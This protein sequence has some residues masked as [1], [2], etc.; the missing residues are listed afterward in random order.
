M[1]LLTL[2]LLVKLTSSFTYYYNAGHA[3]TMQELE[4]T[5]INHWSNWDLLIKLL[6]RR[7]TELQLTLSV[8]MHISPIMQ[9]IATKSILIVQELHGNK[10][11][12]WEDFF[13][14]PFISNVISLNQLRTVSVHIIYVQVLVEAH[15]VEQ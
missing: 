8:L 6:P 9:V 11:S 12:H 14:N 7:Y 15:V 2:L 10:F 5:V 3:Y 4:V 13:V 1:P